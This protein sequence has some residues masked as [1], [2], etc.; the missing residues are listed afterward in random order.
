MAKDEKVEQ[1]EKK[2]GGKG[3]IIALLVVIVLLL[4]GVGVMTMLLLT[5]GDSD[6][7]KSE[8]Q[9]VMQYSPTFKQYPQPKAG[10]PPSYLEMKFVVNFRGEGRARFI[11]VDLNIMSRYPEVIEDMEHLRPILQNDIQMLL[12]QVTYT[13]ISAD[14]GQEVVR[15]RVLEAVKTV[16]EQN[17]I[18]PDLIA[19]IFITRF[20]TQ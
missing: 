9:Q 3:L 8:E 17:G 5:S 12:R 19:N 16:A 20:V 6:K 18:F 10:T 11:A 4:V 15:Q 2:G 14:D 13:E 7:P 1:E